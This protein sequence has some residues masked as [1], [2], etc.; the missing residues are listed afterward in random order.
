MNNT[1]IKSI[2]LNGIIPMFKGKSSMTI[3]SN[4]KMMGFLKKLYPLHLKK[5]TFNFLRLFYRPL[6]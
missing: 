5:T 3:I 1:V 4:R 6:Y 2:N